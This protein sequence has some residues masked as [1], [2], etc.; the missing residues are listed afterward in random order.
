MKVTKEGIAKHIS[1]AMNDH[2][3]PMTIA[4][5]AQKTGIGITKLKMIA[6]D[7]VD[8]NGKKRKL[9][10][11]ELF[12]VADA[13]D[14]TLYQLLSGNDD[15]NHVVCEELGLSNN[16]VNVLKKQ[17][18]YFPHNEMAKLFDLIAKYPELVS[19]LFQYLTVDYRKPKV[20]LGEDE[21]KEAMTYKTGFSEL[22]TTPPETWDKVLLLSVESVLS[23]VKEKILKERTKENG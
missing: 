9:N 3:P 19:Y 8:A 22:H 2:E 16:T 20:L 21:Y 11:D 7:T 1:D 5:L 14:I 18:Q 12:T 23:T 15:A 17:F 4:Q 13:L 10:Y 6:G